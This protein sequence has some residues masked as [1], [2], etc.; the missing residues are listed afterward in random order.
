MTTPQDGDGADIP[1]DG[2]SIGDGVVAVKDSAVVDLTGG[3][4]TPAGSVAFFLCKVD[5][6]ELCD[7]GGTS[8]GSTDLTGAAYPA[9]V[10]S[11]T[12]YVTSAGRYC[13]RGEF[14]GDTENGIP[15]RATRQQTECF[16]VNPVTPTLPTT[17]GPDVNLGNAVTDT[18][19]A[20][21]NGHAAGRPGHQ[22]GRHGRRGSGWNDQFKLLGPAD[23]TTVA[24]ALVTNPQSVA[25][26]GNGTY[27]GPAEQF[28]PTAPGTYHWSRGVH[29]ADL[30][31]N[32]G[33]H[34]QRRLH[35]RRRG[36]GGQRPWPRR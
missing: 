36:R 12:A 24:T 29:A 14:S 27:Y 11:P 33:S 34:A 5:A 8:V 3:T 18:A 7:T 16:T 4:A 32:N 9:T 26:S 21:R 25:V 22:P 19:D 6:P 15:A 23:C 20:E 35:G 2:L 17:A 1:A 10:V 28:T 13:W 31:N 30:P